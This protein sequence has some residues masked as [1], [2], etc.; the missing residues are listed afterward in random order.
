MKFCL[1]GIS[2]LRTLSLTSL[3]IR[4][5]NIAQKAHTR[6]NYRFVLEGEDVGVLCSNVAEETGGT[7]Q[8]WKADHYPATCRYRE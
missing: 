3:K 8:H 6:R 4:N 5:L 2:V 7:P 1:Q